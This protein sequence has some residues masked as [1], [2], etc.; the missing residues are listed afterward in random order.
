M[1]KPPTEIR[2][3]RIGAVFAVLLFVFGTLAVYSIRKDS[4]WNSFLEASGSILQADLNDPN[5]FIVV[6][7]FLLGTFGVLM[8]WVWGWTLLD[9]LMSGGLVDMVESSN[10]RASLSR[11]KKHYIICGAGRTGQVIAEL[12]QKAKKTVVFLDK[13]QPLIDELDEDYY[14]VVGDA[15]DETALERCGI[16]QAA[17]LFVVTNSDSDNLVTV[18][19]SHELRPDLPIYARASTSQFIGRMK[20]AGAKIVVSPEIISGEHLANQMLEQ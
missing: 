2:L 13:S 10:K 8:I 7:R 3:I 18:I 4:L 6:I 14:T 1:T 19:V 9:F 17:G 11:L 15:T 16:R 12:L 20:K 5:P